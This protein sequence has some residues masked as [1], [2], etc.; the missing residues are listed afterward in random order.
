MY[1]I[2]TWDEICTEMPH[3]KFLSSVLGAAL[4][5]KMRTEDI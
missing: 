3:M 5:D 4:W 1:D 2:E